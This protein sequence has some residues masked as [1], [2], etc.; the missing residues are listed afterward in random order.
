VRRLPDG[1]L[2]LPA[3]LLAHEQPY[4]RLTASRLGSYW[5]LVMPYALA[6]GFFPPG[7]AQARGALAYLERHG[8]LLLGLVR[9]GAYALYGRGAP[10]PV[11][12][13]D[14]VY[15]VNLA[16]FLAA[17]DQASE[18]V[19]ALYGDL[20]DAMTPGTFVSGEAA[21]VAPLGNDG[22]RAMYLPPNSAANASFLETL[23]LMVVEETD[24]AGDGADGLEL[25]YAT[26]QTW[27][28]PGRRIRVEGLPT[29]FGP[30]SYAVSAGQHTLRVAIDPP[31][32]P[33]PRLL[34]RLRL[35]AGERITGVRVDGRRYTRVDAAT[36]TIDLTGLRRPATLIASLS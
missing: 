23:R 29:S 8:A 7:G 19:L 18:L 1:T 9:A 2:F 27:L 31:R 28:L 11:S 32:V 34:L 13:T 3:V 26:P 16:R 25:G 15:G 30:V 12:G 6:S 21:S 5:N 14:E 10:Y 36:G 24:G 22:L 17:N 33:P 4:E 35:P 20:A